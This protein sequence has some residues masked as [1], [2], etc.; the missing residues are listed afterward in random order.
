[1]KRFL[2]ALI[3]SLN[4]LFNILICF[5]P[6]IMMHLVILYNSSSIMVTYIYFTFTYIQNE[7]YF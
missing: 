3:S 7:N 4:T 6:L 1:M 2:K 5:P